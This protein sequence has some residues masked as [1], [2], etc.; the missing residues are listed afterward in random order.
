MIHAVKHIFGGNDGYPHPAADA[1]DVHALLSIPRIADRGTGF[2]HWEYA[3]PPGRTPAES[4][5]YEQQGVPVGS[6]G[7]LIAHYS[8]G[9]F[10]VIAHL[11]FDSW[12]AAHAFQLA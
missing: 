9:E 12:E 3:K 6:G 11:T 8:N 1:T 4:A 10:F 2:V 5:M 7:L